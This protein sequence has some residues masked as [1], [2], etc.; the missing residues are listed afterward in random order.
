MRVVRMVAWSHHC[1]TTQFFTL[2]QSRPLLPKQP[3]ALL[4]QL[5]RALCIGLAGRS[6]VRFHCGQQH[7]LLTWQGSSLLPPLR[8][9]VLAVSDTR[10]CVIF[11]CI[12]CVR[13]SRAGALPASLPEFPS[14]SAYTPCAPTRCA[15]CGAVLRFEPLDLSTT[16]CIVHAQHISQYGT[17]TG[18][19][20]CLDSTDLV[21]ADETRWHLYVA[22][23]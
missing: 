13:A 16:L 15:S 18:I 11:V 5:H 20:A 19:S 22:D 21:A 3:I 10:L 6:S 12:T 7:L 2:S 1:H 4:Q 14:G 8:G 23:S 9:T 17:D